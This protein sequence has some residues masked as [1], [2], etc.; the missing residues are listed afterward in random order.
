MKNNV[1][2]EALGITLLSFAICIL[3]VVT[4]GPQEKVI[5]S[6]YI[7]KIVVQSV[8][9]HIKQPL[10]NIS[11]KYKDGIYNISSNDKSLYEEL[12]KF[13]GLEIDAKITKYRYKNE[14][15]NRYDIEPIIQKG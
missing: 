5:D 15:K 1:K 8:K 7:D 3:I 12:E 10:R 2:L 13:E 14:D 11:V 4:L 6:T 9:Y